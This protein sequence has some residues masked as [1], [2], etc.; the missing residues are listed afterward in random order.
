MLNFCRFSLVVISSLKA[1]KDKKEKKGSEAKA[2][3]KKVEKACTV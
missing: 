1:K 3:A 2:M